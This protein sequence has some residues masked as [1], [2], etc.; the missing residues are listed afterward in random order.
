MEKIVGNP[1]RN[2]GVSTKPNNYLCKAYEQLNWCPFIVPNN[3]NE[4]WGKPILIAPFFITINQQGPFFLLPCLWKF[5]VDRK[6][7]P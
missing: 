4:K 5:Q 7:H 2:I 1:L 3:S 6:G